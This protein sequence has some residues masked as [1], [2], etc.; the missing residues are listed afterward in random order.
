MSCVCFSSRFYPK[1][2]LGKPLTRNL[3]EAHPSQVVPC[4]QTD[5][6]TNR[7][8]KYMS[9]FVTLQTCTIV[10]EHRIGGCELDLPGSGYGK[11]TSCCDDGNEH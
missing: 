5:G 11:L 3:T 1:S 8:D 4:G 7:Y 10:D 2:F 6:Q 9:L